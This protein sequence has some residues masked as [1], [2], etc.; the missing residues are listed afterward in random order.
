MLSQ[1]VKAGISA[2]AEL[3]ARRVVSDGFRAGDKND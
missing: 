1:S 2:S 3:S